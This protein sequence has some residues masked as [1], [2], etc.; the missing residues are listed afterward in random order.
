MI[1]TIWQKYPTSVAFTRSRT[2]KKW[3]TRIQGLARAHWNLRGF[4]YAHTQPHDTQLQEYFRF[5]ISIF[6]HFME[7][8]N[9][10]K[11]KISNINLLFYLL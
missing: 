2:G 10:I 8:V 9:L 1:D 4:N 7:K 3:I 6:K 11:Q 5:S